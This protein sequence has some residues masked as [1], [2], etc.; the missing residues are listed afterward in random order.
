MPRPPTAEALLRE[1]ARALAGKGRLQWMAHADV[2][3]RLPHL[4][5]DQLDALIA[6]AVERGWVEAGCRPAHSL[7]LTAVGRRAIE[8]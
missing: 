4:S 1:L 3:A 8:D 2:A 6:V 7:L 5:E